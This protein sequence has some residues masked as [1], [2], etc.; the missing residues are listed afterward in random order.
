MK[1]VDCMKDSMKLSKTIGKIEDAFERLYFA[2][3]RAKEEKMEEN[4]KIG[5]AKGLSQEEI[6]NMPTP[7]AWSYNT[8]Q[9]YKDMAI[10]FVREIN[11]ET[12]YADMKK[13]G[14]C[15]EKHIHSKMEKFFQG[16]ISEAYNMKTLIASSKA[17]NEAILSTKA[18]T[19][20][21]ENRAKFIVQDVDKMQKLLADSNVLRYSAGSKV[22]TPNREELQSVF[23]NI[24]N[25]GHGMKDDDSNMRRIAYVS[26]RLQHASGGRITNTLGLKVDQVREL[27][28]T[29]AITFRKDKGGLTREV[30]EIP[31]DKELRT[32]LSYMIAG[33][34]DNHRVFLA[35]KNDGKFLSIKETRKSVSELV[36]QA[37]SHLSREQNITIKDKDGNKKIV[38]VQKEFSSHSFRK[39]FALERTV[40]YVQR[41]KSVQE[42]EAY[43]KERS[44]S[45]PKIW[46]KYQ[47]VKQRI[48]DP[49]KQ[50]DGT[51]KGRQTERDLTRL[52]FAFFCASVDLGHFRLGIVENYY[53]S[54]EEVIKEYEKEFG[55]YE[56]F[57]GDKK[58]SL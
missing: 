2:K 47:K 40:A 41:F 24:K 57:Q 20:N 8:W 12:G 36:K 58:R 30:V 4:Q 14:P 19:S 16:N 43:I 23:R 45:N 33:K 7:K 22:L 44:K 15:F 32:E 54:P 42:A 55:D 52:E 27:L 48:N 35:K 10:G 1:G 3:A 39:G 46:D 29:G 31:L 38:T 25:Q 11:K 37:G 21:V 56:R 5:E 18:F 6:D 53:C 49:R 17:L 9:T 13:I 51:Y 34:K 50:P 26:S 28:N